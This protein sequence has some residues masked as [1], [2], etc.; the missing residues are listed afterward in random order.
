MSTHYAS[1]SSL[2]C[3]AC[4]DSLDAAPGT[5][6]VCDPERILD[7][8]MVALKPEIDRFEHEFGLY[9]ET[10]HGHLAQWLAERRRTEI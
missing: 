7:R 1:S 4:G 5:A 9:L 3:P 8:L 2:P 6:H 10:A